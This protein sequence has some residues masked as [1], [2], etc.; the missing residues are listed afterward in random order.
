LPIHALRGENILTGRTL[1]AGR[2]PA[3]FPQDS[4][5]PAQRIWTSAAE[6]YTTRCRARRKI[7]KWLLRRAPQVFGVQSARHLHYTPIF[8]RARMTPA[9]WGRPA[10]T[11]ARLFQASPPR[12]CPHS[13]C[14]RFQSDTWLAHSERSDRAR[15]YSPS[16]RAV[17]LAAR[18]FPK[19]ERKMV[20]M[21]RGSTDFV[22]L[23]CHGS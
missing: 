11:P 5:R 1:H 14:P 6:R 18:P 2:A 23:P 15:P 3:P 12:N 7:G 17:F 19:L 20:R 4:T 9:A 10:S 22:M 21:M 8:L 16:V 13:R